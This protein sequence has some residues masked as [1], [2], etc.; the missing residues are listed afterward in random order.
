MRERLA[1]LLGTVRHLEVCGQ[2][3]S[4]STAIASIRATRVDAVILDIDLKDGTGLEVLKAI[5]QG[6]SGPIVIVLTIHPFAELGAPFIAAGANHY[7]EKGHSFDGVLDLLE[8]L[9][10]HHAKQAS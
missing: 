7:F 8:E 3:S 10:A 2:A 6:T 1:E 4:V 9:S 5:K